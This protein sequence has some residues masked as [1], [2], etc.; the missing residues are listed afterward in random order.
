MA[1]RMNSDRFN[2]Q[3]AE[4]LLE[5]FAWAETRFPKMKAGCM[6]DPFEPLTTVRDKVKGFLNIKASET[7]D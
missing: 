6:M 5:L 1:N 7:E 2:K 3:E 4:A